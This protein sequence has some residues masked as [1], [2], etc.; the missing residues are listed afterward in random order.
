[1]F[2][3]GGVE[4]RLAL[5]IYPVERAPKQLERSRKVVALFQILAFL[6]K[7]L[8]V[9]S[10]LIHPVKIEG[11]VGFLARFF[12]PALV[13][14]ERAFGAEDLGL[15]IP[16]KEIPASGRALPTAENFVEAPGE[17]SR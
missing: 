17:S 8:R 6:R 10:V 14:A 1:M 2:L 5:G 11:A 3:C 13:P 12:K 4:L 16:R 15:P 7:T 9:V